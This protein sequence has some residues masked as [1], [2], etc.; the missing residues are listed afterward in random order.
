MKRYGNS[1]SPE[2]TTTPVRMMA[3]CSSGRV[4]PMRSAA[5][6][7]KISPNRARSR[8]ADAFSPPR[9]AGYAP[10]PRDPRARRHRPP[11]R[12]RGAWLASR[13]LPVRARRLH[14]L[15]DGTLLADSYHCSRLQHQYGKA[16]RRDVRNSVRRPRLPSSGG[17]KEGRSGMSRLSRVVL[18]QDAGPAALP[19]ALLLRLTLV[20]L[21]LPSGEAEFDLGPAAF[22]EIDG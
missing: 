12:T 15:P 3:S 22:V 7:H 14:P 11:Q 4:S 19:V 18:A 10:A 13:A 6:P 16:H 20:G 17:R 8:P 5:C 2:G 21:S 9:S 1:A